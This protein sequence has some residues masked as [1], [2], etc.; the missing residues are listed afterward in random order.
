[1]PYPY[2]TPY[3]ANLYAPAPQTYQQYP[4]MVQN[5]PPQQTQAGAAG[6]GLVW[7]Q[8]E[9]GAKSYLVAPNTTVLLMDS[10]SSR[11]YL[12]SADTSG[13]PLPLRVFSYTEDTEKPP[14]T[15]NYITRQEFEKRLAEITKK[16]AER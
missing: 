11:F 12:K 10:E 9:S 5:A 16:E 3:N 15:A 14:E 7:V 2:T 4:N 13:M 6:N 1:M 8:G